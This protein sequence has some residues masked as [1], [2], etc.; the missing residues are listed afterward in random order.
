MMQNLQRFWSQLLQKWV[1]N[2]SHLQI[3][4]ARSWDDSSISKTRDL[5]ISIFFLSYLI[6]CWLLSKQGSILRTVYVFLFTGFNSSLLFRDF[7]CKKNFE[8]SCCFFDFSC[9]AKTWYGLTAFL[10][11]FWKLCA[12]SSNGI[13]KM[14]QEL[15]SVN[16][17]SFWKMPISTV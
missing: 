7:F 14:P 8:M 15:L 5:F 13:W 6:F 12:L 17:Y 9:C 4:T 11:L 16:N 10:K 1:A 3:T 2:F